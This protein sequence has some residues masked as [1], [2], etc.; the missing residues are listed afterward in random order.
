MKLSMVSYVTGAALTHT[1]ELDGPGLEEF[2]SGLL[3]V[4]R[5]THAWVVT[6][7]TDSG[8]MKLV[9]NT[10]AS[11]G[12]KRPLIGVAAWGVVNG[13]EKLAGCHGGTVRYAG[14]E[15]ASKGGAPLNPHH[16]HFIFVD[17][18]KEGKAAAACQLHD[19][20]VLAPRDGGLQDRAAGDLG[21]DAAYYLVERALESHSAAPSADATR[22]LDAAS[23]TA[24]R[25]PCRLASR[26]RRMRKT[27]S[28]CHALAL[29]LWSKH[30]R[31]NNQPA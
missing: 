13:R 7:G 4:A 19:G 6:G 25:N 24:P 20:D 26:P 27:A 17:N 1:I 18:G 12:H 28:T 31:A 9:G 11:V 16:T 3:A 29:R 22:R 14:V 30:G 2:K 5:K 21:A 23:A 10:M 8:V 15:A